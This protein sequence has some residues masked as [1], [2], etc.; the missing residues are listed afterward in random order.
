M[1]RTFRS[2]RRHHAKYLATYAEARPAIA[3]LAAIALVGTSGVAAADTLEQALVAAFAHNPSLKGS[4]AL[5]RAAEEGVTEAK[6]AFGPTLGLEARHA[7]TSARIRGPTVSTQDHGFA[8][9][10]E[11]TLSQPLF[12]SGSLSANLDAARAAEL[13]ERERLRAAS[14]KLIRD[15]VDAYVSVQR[16]I[17]LYDV[18]TE[19]HRLLEQQRDT[20]TARFRL[21]DA[22]EPDVDQTVN[23]LELSAARVI[24]ARSDVE[25]SAARYRNLVGTYPDMLA[26]LPALP[27]TPGLETLYAAAETGNPALAAARYTEVRSRALIGAARARMRPQVNAFATAARDPL[28][29]YQNTLREESVTAGI[30][31]TM[32]LYTGGQQSAAVREEI[33]RN[34]ADQQFIEQTRRDVRESLASDWSVLQA[35]TEAMPRY[36]TAVRAAE[37]AVEGVRQQER[38]GIRTLREVLEVTNDLLTAHT[39]AVQARAEMYLRHVAVLRDAGLLDIGMFVPTDPGDPDDRHPQHGA[40]AGLPLRPLAEPLDR[41]ILQKGGAKAAVQREEAARFAWPGDGATAKP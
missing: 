5:A 21:R 38:S 24:A 15:V 12:T 16:D 14:Q 6:G 1:Q 34:L 25:T 11:L 37:S 26:P 4:R 41:L 23:R 7:Y 13:I 35:T 31:L 19:I 27:A 29:P 32:P 3:A 22:T 18:A 9:S 28:T 39:E 30:S 10:A 20:T 33:E 17:A 40:L 2:A 8:T 36:D